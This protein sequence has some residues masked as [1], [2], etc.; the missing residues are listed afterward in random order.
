VRKSLISDQ[1]LFKLGALPVIQVKGTEDKLALS[2]S[3]T[4]LDALS[5][6]K[7]VLFIIFKQSSF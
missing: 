5:H 2:T 4:I 7:M 6:F 3:A 1:E